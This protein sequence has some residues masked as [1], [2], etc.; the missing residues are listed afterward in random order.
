MLDK[1]H[2]C[3]KKKIEKTRMHSDWNAEKNWYW[4]KWTSSIQLF[5][6]FIALIAEKNL[7]KKIIE[8]ARKKNV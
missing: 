1:D 2:S 8:A 7:T 4:E 5:N 6:G 3:Q